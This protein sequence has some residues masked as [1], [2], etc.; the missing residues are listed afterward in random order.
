[1][2]DFFFVSERLNQLHI[3]VLSNLTKLNHLN[4]T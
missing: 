3:N 4:I 1:M 2:Q